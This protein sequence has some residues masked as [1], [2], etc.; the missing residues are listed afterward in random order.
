MEHRS[1]LR[2]FLIRLTKRHGRD[3]LEA[4]MPSEH[5]KMLSHALKM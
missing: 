4:M 3:S 1:V 2:H 5:V